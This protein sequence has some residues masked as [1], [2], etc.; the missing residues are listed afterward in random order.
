MSD[1]IREC[2]LHDAVDHGLDLRTEPAAVRQIAGQVDLKLGRRGRPHALYQR[3]ERRLEAEIVESRGA[4]VGDDP[5]QCLNGEVDASGGGIERL[6][7]GG[8]AVGA[9]HRTE[10]ELE[11]GKLLQRLV[12]KLTCPAPSLPLCRVDTPTKHLS[13]G[14]PGTGHG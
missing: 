9:P 1:R 10:R 12:V 3:L 8:I 4:Q 13:G 7:A 14:V 5:P 6:A 11:P 2:F